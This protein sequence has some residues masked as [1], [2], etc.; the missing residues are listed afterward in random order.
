VRYGGKNNKTSEQNL[1]NPVGLGPTTCGLEGHR[2]IQLSYGLM[3]GSAVLET[4]TSGLKG[5]SSAA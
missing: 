1:V 5:R 4:A 3:V 2:S